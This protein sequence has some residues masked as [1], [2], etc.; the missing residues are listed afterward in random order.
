MNIAEL[1]INFASITPALILIVTALI[2]MLVDAF[3]K[4][5]RTTPLSFLS[6]LGVILAALS[7]IMLSRTTHEGF[8][9]MITHDGLAAFGTFAVCIGAAITLLV[10][11]RDL[12]NHQMRQGEYFTLMLLATSGMAF[13]MSASDL[14]MFFLGLELMS[15]PIYALAGFNRRSLRSGESAMKYFVLGAFA[16]GLLLYGTALIYGAVG[17]T[18]YAD[19]AATV[20]EIGLTGNLYLTIGT[21]LILV[22]LGFK[23]GA[24]PFHMWV[25]DVYQGAPTSITGFMGAAVKA[26]GF[27]ALARLVF[28]VFV[29]AAEVL[30][31]L[32]WALAAVTMI[33]GN[34]LALVQSN[35][36]RMLAY[37]S[38][39]HA[40]FLLVA[41]VVGT[42]GALSALL[43]YLI[44][45]AVA[46]LGAFAA[47]IAISGSE[48]AEDIETWAGV[49]T[50]R[51][52]V[53]FAMMLCM[54]SLAGIPP[55]AGFLG[56]FY[57][58]KEAIEAG[59]VYLALVAVIASVI[60]VYYYLRVIVFMY[61][62]EGAA[63]VQTGT[64]DMALNIGLVITSVAIAFF[65]ILPNWLLEV[66]RN[67]VIDLF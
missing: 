64:R 12:S 33:V 44:V 46:N 4:E 62:K 47:T 67:S 51:P 25:P 30:T 13:L 11:N 18:N 27:V 48:D 31:P 22:A 17:S 15:I 49:S 7:A 53:A 39:S 28:V 60:G 26:A 34:I 65:G 56:K 23:V 59:F 24:V 2:V 42:S 9:G 40:G 54:L 8:S 35:V 58:F 6:L 38:V 14:V 20:S 61:M 36:K 45:Y 10:S 52:F 1:N 43:F 19:I 21:A 50:R 5:G 57:L 63:G 29:D 41:I 55:T 66:A 16:T 3:S 32:L 37:S